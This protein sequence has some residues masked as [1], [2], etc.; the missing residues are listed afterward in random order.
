[1]IN[2]FFNEFKRSITYIAEDIY[3]NTRLLLFNKELLIL[4]FILFILFI[5]LAYFVYTNYIKNIVDTKHVLNKELTNNNSNIFDEN[6]NDIIIVFF[7]TDWC[8]S[9]KSSEPEWQNFENY[10]KKIN[11]I[12]KKQIKCLKIDCDRYSHIADKF[13]IEAYPTIK[14]FYNGEIYD[15]ESKITKKRLIMFVESFVDLN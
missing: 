14:M 3:I 4:S 10:V 5:S 1:M 7:K 15:Y 2:S 8:P 12:N 13:E 6:I 11:K 9:C